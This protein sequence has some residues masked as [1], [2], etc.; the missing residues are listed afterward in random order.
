VLVDTLIDVIEERDPK[1]LYAKAR[2]GQ[3]A[4]LTG[5]DSSHEEPVNRY[6]YVGAT[7]TDPASEADR[8]SEVRVE[9]GVLPPK[10]LTR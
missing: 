9:V 5:V 4:H 6:L 10:T 2:A 1:G 7:T 8:I 3:L